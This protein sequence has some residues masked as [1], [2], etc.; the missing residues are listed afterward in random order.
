MNANI[1]T[2]LFVS[3]LVGIIDKE[4][5]ETMELPRCGVKD[6]IEMENNVRR[7]RFAIQG[8]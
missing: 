7:K 3:V 4:T 8:L 1:N 5:Q 2:T 6:N